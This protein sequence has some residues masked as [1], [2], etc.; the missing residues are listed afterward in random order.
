MSARGRQ[1]PVAPEFGYVQSQSSAEW[2]AA[3]SGEAG[4]QED[5][6][7]ETDTDQWCTVEYIE[8]R[9]FIDKKKAGRVVLEF[10]DTQSGESALLFL[11]VDVTYQRGPKKGSPKPHG[12]NGEF[13]PPR[14]GRFR[15]LW[16]EIVAS[17]PLAWA[18]VNKEL[19]KLRDL[20]LMAQVV[21][22]RGSDGV[23]FIKITELKKAG[24]SCAGTRRA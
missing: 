11:N 6:V 21:P 2:L 13:L 5:C 8:H 18:R 4:T 1:K 14:R 16:L 20:T 12:K 9:T 17:R 15:K 3:Y 24:R 10:R 22:T 23:V 7:G 19:Y